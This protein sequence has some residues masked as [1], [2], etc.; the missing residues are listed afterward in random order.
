MAKCDPIAGLGVRT[1]SAKTSPYW[2]L[3][4]SQGRQ[5]KEIGTG[6]TP[7]TN[8]TEAQANTCCTRRLRTLRDTDMNVIAG[9]ITLLRS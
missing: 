7:L 6:R 3:G 5:G 2:W 1:T 9:S 8:C 4:A